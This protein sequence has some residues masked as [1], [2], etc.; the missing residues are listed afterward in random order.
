[1]DMIQSKKNNIMLWAL[2]LILGGF[3]IINQQCI[4][5]NYILLQFIITVLL[6]LTAIFLSLRKTT[7]G[8][9]FSRYWLEA[10]DELKKVTWPNKKETMQTTL[11]VVAMVFVMG[12]ILWTVDSV[13]IRLVAW[14][15]QRGSV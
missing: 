15:L 12:L 1:M 14:L 11:A 13:L 2:A 4:H 9:R 5:Y 6:V 10:I 3:S 8:V 7:Q